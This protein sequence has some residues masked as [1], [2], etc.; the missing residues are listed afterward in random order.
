KEK[1]SLIFSISLKIERLNIPPYDWRNEALQGVAFQGKAT[2]F[3][4]AIGMAATWNESLVFEIANAISDEARARHHEYA[5]NN[6]RE[7]WCGLTFSTPNINIVRDPR[8]G[9]GQETFGEDP[10][11]TSRMGVAFCKGLQGNHPHYLK[12]CSEP[13]HFAVHSGP[14]KIRHKINNLVSKKD[15]Y[16]TY[17]PAFKACIREGKA[18][19]LMGAYSRLNGEPCCASKELLEETLRKQFGFKG[20]VIGDGGAIRDI[21]KYHKLVDTFGEAA[22]LALNNGLSI[23]NP[24]NIQTKAKLKSLRKKVLGAIERK[25][26][27]EKIIDQ[28]LRRSLTARFKLGMFDPPEL[29]PY[30]KIPFSIIDCENH[31]ALALRAGKESYILLKN[32]NNF[33]PLST[34]NDFKKIAIIGPLA[35]NP[36]S[37]Y[38]PHYYL[39]PPKLVTYLEGLKNKLDKSLHVSYEPGC[40][41]VNKDQLDFS[42]AI[43]L[44]Q[45]SDI[46]CLFL[47]LTGE[48]EGE[49]GYVIGPET[50]DR[51]HLDLPEVQNLL[52]ENL[53][54]IRKK[55]ILIL[56]SGSALAINQAKNHKN[57]PSIIQAFYPGEEGG[58]ALADILMGKFNPCGRLPITFYKSVNDLPNYT[59]YDMKNRTYRYFEGEPLYHFG[60]GL[61]Y[62]TF[63]YGNLHIAPKSISIGQDINIAFEIENSG[64]YSGNEVIQLYLKHNIED[65]KT[66]IWEL[67][68]F[69]KVFMEKGSTRKIK[70]QLNKKDYGYIN[71][72]GKDT[73]SSEKIDLSI[74]GS[75]PSL[76]IEKSGIMSSINIK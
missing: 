55:I 4:Q 7:R 15:L 1:V 64:K 33:L 56:T 2:I 69:K 35:D 47:G 57:V 30:T 8:W 31:R 17:L 58:N 26:V 34:D 41:L 51:T 23:I 20:Y 68:R 42:K 60:H 28:A 70:F 18:E 12:T 29:V 48:I 13:K 36:L 24:L 14:E 38:Y 10:Y 73:V 76:S 9:R 19:G 67:K 75:H 5:R 53:I 54:S 71:K 63:N 45:N 62:T 11:L 49:E 43:D 65:F 66:P 27:S 22:A 37:L 21:H 59:N 74:G 61:S 16:E 39:S 50:G 52:L 3:P 44:A 72:N 46:V 25:L 6:K 40:N 32:E